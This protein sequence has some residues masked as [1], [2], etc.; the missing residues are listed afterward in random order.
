MIELRRATPADVDVCLG[1][2]KASV[3]VGYAHIFNQATHPFPDEPIREE[4]VRRI[5]DPVLVTIAEVDGVGSGVIGTRGQRVESL[6]VVP[7][8]WGSGLSGRL[9]DEALAVIADAGYD[10]AILDVLVDN[11]RARR[12]Y[13]RRGWLQAGEPVESPWDPFP[14]MVRY[15]R[16]LTAADRR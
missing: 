5:S 2:Q 7:E 6:F 4:W 11:D 10:E 16:P 8:Q 14:L 3:L 13:E 15:R 9:H 12:F 1:I